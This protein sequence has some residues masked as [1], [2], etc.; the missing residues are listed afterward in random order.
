MLTY[1]LMGII[2]IPGIIFAIWAQIRVSTKFE[3]YNKEM[4]TAAINGAEFARRILEAKGITDVTVINSGRENMSDH[5]NPRTKELVLSETSYHGHS[6]SS[7]GVTAHEVGHAIQHAEGYTLLKLRNILIPIANFGSAFL[8]MVIILSVI[9]V[10]ADP[11]STF[12]TVMLWLG[13]GIFGMIA[14]VSLI[15]LPVEID[16]SNRAKKM[17][18]AT[19]TLSEGEMEGA[20]EV[21]GAAALTYVA[22]LLLAILNLIRFLSIFMR[23]D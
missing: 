7:L 5:Y 3:K 21:L 22:A 13:V 19:E 12:T 23:R 1:Y 17:L 11:Y 2:L 18:A 6:I 10:L 15:T 14:L 9:T 4:V 16:A 20:K 8:S